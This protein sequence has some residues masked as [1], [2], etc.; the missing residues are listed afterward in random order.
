MDMQ[1]LREAGLTE[2]EAK[3]YLALLEIGVSTAGPITDRADVAKSIIYQLLEKLIK[4]GLVSYIVKE[5]TKYFQAAP[6]TK[7]I[8]YVD[9]RRAALERTRK[10]IEGLL[11]ELMLKQRS[12]SSEVRVYE[13]FKGLATVHENVFHRLK[14]GEWYFHMGIPVDQ[15][16]YY[17][18]YWT[19]QHKR[20][21]QFGIHCRLLFNKDNPKK[22]LDIVNRTSGGDARY[23]PLD[24]HTIA[25]FGGYKDYAIISFASSSPITI[26]IRNKEIAASFR[27][28]FDEFWKQSK[29]L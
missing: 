9:E 16:S 27:S 3:V 7:I 14:R 20:R 10:K 15:P 21:A 19:K 26:E 17:I 8:D 13:G 1:F 6:P 22:I 11:P 29:K 23:M 18:P 24:T 5:K 25:W 2:G 12:A 4:K 28:Y